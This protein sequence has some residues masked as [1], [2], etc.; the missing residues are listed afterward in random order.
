MK[1]YVLRTNYVTSK[2][3]SEISFPHSRLSNILSRSFICN[4]LKIY[5]CTLFVKLL[6]QQ[7]KVRKVENLKN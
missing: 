3:F 1:F 6:I 5:I 2:F 4:V 7:R